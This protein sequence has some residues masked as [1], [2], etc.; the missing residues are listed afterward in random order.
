MRRRPMPQDNF[1]AV[2]E[3]VDPVALVEGL[4]EAKIKEPLVRRRAA[5]PVPFL[6]VEDRVLDHRLH[7]LQK[8]DE[9][10]LLARV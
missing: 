7:V 2:R 5:R 8:E 9:G 6:S 4:T 1:A 3:R 10:P